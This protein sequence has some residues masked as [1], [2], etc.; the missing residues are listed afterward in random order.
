[1]LSFIQT[2][3]ILLIIIMLLSFIVKLLKQPIILGYV[4]SGL[5]FSFLFFEDT[6][7]NEQVIIFSQLG[8]TFLLFFM[9]LEFDFKSLK[10]LRK[11]IF[12]ATLWQSIIFFAIAF[13][14]A[15]CFGFSLIEKVYLSILFMFSST[16]LVAKWVADKKEMTSLHGKIIIGTLVI[17]DLF[18][19]IILTALSVLKE[20]SFTQ[21][22]LVPLGGLVLALLAFLFARYFLNFP[23][24]LGSKYPEFL[25]I[26]SISVCFI[27]V[28]FALLLGYSSTIG[29]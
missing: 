23:L 17:Q 16:L 10:F 9:G 3:G 13:G 15:S 18:A 8:I 29:A 24:R 26:L 2:F 6:G 5:V 21:I 28:E 20:E 19:I 1:M 25:F 22:L 12:I 27:F 7:I 11:D 4:L 14:L